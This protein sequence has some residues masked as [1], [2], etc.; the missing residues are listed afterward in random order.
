MEEPSYAILLV[1]SSK[2]VGLT[3]SLPYFHRIPTRSEAPIPTP[4]FSFSFILFLR[5]WQVTPQQR[6]YLFIYKLF[7]LVKIFS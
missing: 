7:A 5:L 4:A 6:V 2:R 3:G 1:T